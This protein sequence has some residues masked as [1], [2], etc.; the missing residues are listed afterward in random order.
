MSRAGAA[1]RIALTEAAAAA[2]GVPAYFKT[3]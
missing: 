1:G 2:M 3:N